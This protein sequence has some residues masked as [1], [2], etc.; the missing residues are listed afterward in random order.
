MALDDPDTARI[1][2]FLESIGIPVRIEPVQPDS[3]LPGIAIHS[4]GLA[5]DPSRPFY[6]GDLLHEAGHI[7]VTDPALRA[8]GTVSEDPGDEMAAIAW[9]Y[10]AV[11]AIGLNSRIV[12]HDHGY[13]GGGPSLAEAF[14]SGSYPGAPMLQYYGMSAE[15]HQAERLMLAPYPQM[16]RWLR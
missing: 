11:R 15:P 16:S 12:F 6:P 3:F 8:T 13:R 5:V 14:D 9:S 10:A 4:G 2:A 7:A 1:V